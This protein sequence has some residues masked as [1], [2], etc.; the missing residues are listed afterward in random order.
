MKTGDEGTHSLLDIFFPGLSSQRVLKQSN[1]FSV[2]IAEHFAVNRVIC[3][4]HVAFVISIC[5]VKNFNSV[6]QNG[7][8]VRF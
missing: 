4:S 7:E 2:A 8:T 1:A 6:G 5:D 3:N